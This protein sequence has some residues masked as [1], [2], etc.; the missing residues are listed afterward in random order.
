[1]LSND[2]LNFASGERLSPWVAVGCFAMGISI[3]IFWATEVGL[4][5]YIVFFNISWSAS[6]SLTHVECKFVEVEERCMC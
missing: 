2:H 6:S 3:I 5:I 1:M 4:V